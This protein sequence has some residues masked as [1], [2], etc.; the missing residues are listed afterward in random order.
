M[1]NFLFQ[2]KKL[3][4]TNEVYYST[5]TSL[6]NSFFD[7]FF[8]NW[9]TSFNNEIIFCIVNGDINKTKIYDSNFK[10]FVSIK[11]FHDSINPILNFLNYTFQVVDDNIL[12][13]NY[14]IQEFPNNTFGIEF[15]DFQKIDIKKFKIK[16]LKERLLFDG[17]Y[18][19]YYD[20][21][22]KIVYFLFKKEQKVIIL[23]LK[24][25][26]NK[27][28]FYT[29]AFDIKYNF[30]NNTN[31]RF[32]FFD[33]NI[34]ILEKNKLIEIN[35]NNFERREL[36]IQNVIISFLDLDD[37]NILLVIENNNNE[38]KEEINSDLRKNYFSFLNKN[39][40][41]LEEKKIYCSKNYWYEKRLIKINDNE[42]YFGG[43]IFYYLPIEKNLIKIN[44]FPE[45]SSNYFLRY[46]KIYVI[47]QK[48]INVE[49]SEKFCENL[50]KQLWKIN[51]YEI[52]DEPKFIV[53]KNNDKMLICYKDYDIK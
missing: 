16:P 23:E 29:K 26:K 52:S 22:L 53:E 47:E 10:E 51:L 34:Y 7:S 19:I 38:Q 18:S 35:L 8:G 32:K 37:N 24:D 1:K 6:D 12:I 39:K 49:E 33:N 30:E 25:E 20:Y 45:L 4:K 3:I 28:V 5:Y 46:G 44:N 9:Y 13:Q 43:N 17:K 27:T 14:S 31:Y 11:G 41:I 21:K 40:F 2:K 50:K 42:I 15:Y 36:V 48:Y